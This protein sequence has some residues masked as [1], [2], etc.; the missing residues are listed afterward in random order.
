MNSAGAPNTFCVRAQSNQPWC[1]SWAS[2]LNRRD[3][4]FV[5]GHPCCEWNT[6][7]SLVC[8]AKLS[9]LAMN[10]SLA[11]VM[12]QDIVG[13]SGRGL[14]TNGTCENLHQQVN[15]SWKSQDPG[16]VYVN[17]APPWLLHADSTQMTNTMAPNPNFRTP[18]AARRTQAA[19]RPRISG[20]PLRSILC[21]E[22]PRRHVSPG[23]AIVRI[24]CATAG[25]CAPMRGKQIS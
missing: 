18:V 22:C 10:A 11:Q 15:M 7:T 3:Y 4:T 16:H 21:S 5:G 14:R 13:G 8:A 9:N 6:H 12:W 17:V 19:R 2:T 1:C 25:R 24:L 23:E 20:H